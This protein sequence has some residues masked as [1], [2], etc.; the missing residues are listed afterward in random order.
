MTLSIRIKH[1]RAVLIKLYYL[2][3]NETK[4]QLTTQKM[5]NKSFFSFLIKFIFLEVFPN[6]TQIKMKKN[7]D[8]I[9]PVTGC[10]KS[11]LAQ[12]S[13]SQHFI[14]FITYEWAK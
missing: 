11:F 13:Y 2:F 3:K 9:D 12:G 5:I 14:F 7:D 8:R 6:F 10:L 4:S 1:M